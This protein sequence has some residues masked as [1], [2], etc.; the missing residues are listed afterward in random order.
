[1]N[2]PK[3]KNIDIIT[4]NITTS[5]LIIEFTKLIKSIKDINFCSERVLQ[6]KKS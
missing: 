2:I 5:Q 6:K 4:I 1:M 3:Y